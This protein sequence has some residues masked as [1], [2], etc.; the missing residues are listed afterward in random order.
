MILMPTFG[1]CALRQVDPA[2]ATM[3]LLSRGK[4]HGEDN[5]Q[6]GTSG[7]H[8]LYG[9]PLYS[10][11]FVGILRLIASDV[12]ALPSYLSDDTPLRWP[13]IDNPKEPARYT[14]NPQPLLAIGHIYEIRIMA[15]S[16]RSLTGLRNASQLTLGRYRGWS[17]GCKGRA[18]GWRRWYHNCTR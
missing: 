15:R 16:D 6:L 3:Q 8:T 11:L 14:R 18:Y 12:W 4:G 5:S 7:S 9:I 10:I 1:P 13:S 17:C 2:F